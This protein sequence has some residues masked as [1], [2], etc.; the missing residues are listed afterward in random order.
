[1]KEY[2]R[3]IKRGMPICFGYIPVAFAFGIQAVKSGMDPLWATIM[4][5]SNMASAGQVNGLSRILE[6]ATFISVIITT[7]V[8]NMRYTLMSFSLTQKIV[9]DM[10][11]YKRCIMA[12]CI[13]DEMFVFASMEEHDITFEFYAGLVTMPIVGWTLGTL[14]GGLATGLFS[15]MIQGCLGITLYSMFIAIIIPETRKSKKVAA[16]ST[17]AILL[18]CIFTYVP[19]INV[20]SKGGWGMIISA[21]VAA[22]MGATIKEVKR[23]KRLKLQSAMNPI[24]MEEA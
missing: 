3:G 19:F 18:T 8:V 23:R 11:W 12:F 1:M 4:A 17:C 21:I 2:I 24:K 6:N 22:A 5:F 14:L 10:P 7:L 9:H 16:V 20:L 15:P 13:C